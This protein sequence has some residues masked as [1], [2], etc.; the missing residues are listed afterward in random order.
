MKL[1]TALLWVCI[2]SLTGVSTLYKLPAH[3]LLQSYCVVGSTVT[4]QQCLCSRNSYL[5]PVAT[6]NWTEKHPQHATSFHQ[7]PTVV[8]LAIRICEREIISEIVKVLNSFKTGRKLFAELLSSS[9]R[10]F[11]R[12]GERINSQR[13]Y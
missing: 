7:S 4:A 11:E 8:M 9:V 6:E 10:Y 12:R 1:D 5:F 13:F 3:Y 2:N